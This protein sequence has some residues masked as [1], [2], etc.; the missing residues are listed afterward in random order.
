MEE[1]FMRI[2]II[3]PS[4]TE[5]NRGSFCYAPYLLYNGLTEAGHDVLLIET[6]KP[7]DL[8][9]I[10]DADAHIITLWSYP[11]I[12][13][14]LL[15]SHFIPFEKNK[16]N[17][18]FAGYT[19]LI[20]AQGLRHVKELLE[21]DPL[22]NNDFM[23]TAMK[24]YPVYF[25]NFKR[26]LL[27]DCD[28][29]LKSLEEGEKVYPM[30]TTYGCPNGCSFCP[31]TIN[32]GKARFVLTDDE[33]YTMLIQTIDKGIKSIHFTDEDFFYDIDRAHR[34]LMM[35]QGLGM[36]LIALG[37]AEV[38]RQYI[39]KY[40]TTMIKAAG[41]EVIEIGFE[42]GNEALSKQMGMGKSLSDCEWLAHR[43][44]GYPFHI[45]WLVQTFFPGETITSLNDTGAFMQKHGFSQQEVV[46]RLRTNGT[47]GGLGQ[48]F[49]P[50]DGTALYQV[51]HKKGQFL[52]DRPVRLLPSYLP[53]SFLDSQITDVNRCN[54]SAAEEWLV[55]YNLPVNIVNILVKGDNVRQ[56]IEHLKPY[57]KVKR[58]IAL[59][60]LARMSVIS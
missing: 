16:D 37:S 28:M 1:K 20:H 33:V 29:H 56:H 42:S 26:L 25:D 17:V 44:E 19:P 14:S 54:M 36:H 2:N 35:L 30:F 27:S 47:Q 51:L 38:V 31:S 58:A 34:I 43:Q 4:S 7:E 48:F 3:D 46:G 53:D 5:F 21:F 9:T 49:Q 40:G 50:Y 8:D 24:T 55:L 52:T 6:F 59:A 32:C 10:P 18:Y 13:T 22:V 39:E 45:F 15:L 23:I 41:L 60:I 57:E 12:D 11:Q